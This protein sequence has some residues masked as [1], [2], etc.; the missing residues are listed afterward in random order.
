[1]NTCYGITI[2]QQQQQ[3]KKP[4]QTSICFLSVVNTLIP[5]RIRTGPENINSHEQRF[6]MGKGMSEYCYTTT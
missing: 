1:M 3:Q 4:E 2:N 5:I 6:F